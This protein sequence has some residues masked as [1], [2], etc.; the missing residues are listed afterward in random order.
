M[1]KIF[2][3]DGFNW[4]IG[5]VED[6]MDPEKM[7]RLKVRIFGYHTDSKVILPTKDLP[8]ATPIQPITSAAISGI[9]SSPIGPVEGTWVIGFFLDGEDMQQPA[10][11]GTIATKAA[12]KAFSFFEDKPQVT[13][14]NDGVLK[15]GSG[16]VVVDG[17]G[18]P[19]RVGTPQVEGWELGQTSEKYESGG[20][21][22]GTINAYNG[23]AGGDLG[24]ASYGTYQLASYL[25]AVM[26][27]GKARPSAKN[28]PVVQFLNN[29]KFKDKFANLEPATAAFDAKWTEIANTYKTEFK[30]EQHEYIQRKYYNVAVA[31][32]QRQ[33]LDLTKYGPAVQDL[34]WSGAVQFGPA[35]I[36]AFTE[37]LRDKSTLTDKDIVTLVSEW[38]INNVDTLF[39]SSS[40][41]IRAGVKS[42]YQSEKTALLKLIK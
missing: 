28:S 6:R 3:K 34:I 4:W 2:N 37:A 19:V 36:K 29:S 31:N 18:N 10:V 14:P 5:V 11:F 17:S 32:L 39:K 9:G 24:G 42:R 35:N 20:K 40:E 27:N 30:D 15:D 21:G 25:P 33:G 41:S 38:K 7:G 1:Q 26:T 16:N 12:K 13:N 22:P 23:A 8:W